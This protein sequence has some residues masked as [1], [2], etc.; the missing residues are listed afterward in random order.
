MIPAMMD[1]MLG[2]LQPVP[3]SEY[4]KGKKPL[5]FVL[6]VFS[7]AC[8]IARIYPGRDP[9]GGVTWGIA[10]GLGWW[11]VQREMDIQGICC[12]GFLCLLQGVFDAAKVLDVA[13][14]QKP[15]LGHRSP[16]YY[17][18]LLCMIIS[19]VLSLSISQISYR[20]YKDYDTRAYWSGENGGLRGI[21][22]SADIGPPLVPYQGK[23]HRLV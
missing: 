18:L 7:T 23:G 4:A 3:P 13:V 10:I 2:S 5:F 19:A 14:H 21:S 17:A 16:L 20:I 8:V 1:F 15:H 6:L 12:C 11:A 9:L 22:L